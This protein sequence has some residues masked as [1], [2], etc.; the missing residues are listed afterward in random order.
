MTRLL[1]NVLLAVIFT[2]SSILAF[3]QDDMDAI[4][5]ARPHPMPTS[6]TVEGDIIIERFFP[7][8]KQGTVGLVRLIGPDVVQAQLI[9]LN[10]QYS[11]FQ[12]SDNEW[13]LFLVA[14]MDVQPR[15]YE[16]TISIERQS[17]NLDI[18]QIVKVES[19]DYITEEFD[20][21]GDLAELVDPDLEKAE[22]TKIDGIIE[23]ISSEALWDA[24]GFGLPLDS[25]VASSFGTYRLLNQSIS[26]RHTGWDQ[27]APMGTA[28]KTVGTGRVI[29]AGELDI[30]GNYVLVDHG[31][32]IYSGY[33]H[34]SQIHVT[35]G[36]SITKGQIVGMSG[37]TGRSGGAHLHWEML[38]NGEW[39]D[40]RMFVKM[41]LPS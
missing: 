9:F 34:L 2:L 39:V 13:Y 28:I 30:R 31:Y 33:A 8:I 32:G 15:D 1:T 10:N 26:T 36:Q 37:N 25:Q 17:N 40:S 7:S 11:F 24:T 23:N 29:F 22:Y 20:M 3:T 12:F 35:S 16:V 21:L 38:V 5:Q 4:P 6:V 18:S 19:A 27:Q 14:N 41:W